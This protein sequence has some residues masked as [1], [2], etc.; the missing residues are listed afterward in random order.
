MY[1][2]VCKTASFTADGVQVF[3]NATGRLSHVKVSTKLSQIGPKKDK[4][5]TFYN[6]FSVQFGSGTNLIQPDLMCGQL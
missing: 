3:T 6:Q 5:G 4:C 1:L 2:C